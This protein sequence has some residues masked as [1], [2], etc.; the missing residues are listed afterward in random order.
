MAMIFDFFKAVMMEVTD[1][2]FDLLKLNNVQTVLTEAHLYALRN[3][4]TSLKQLEKKIHKEIP[5][6]KLLQDFRQLLFYLK[7][8]KSRTTYQTPLKARQAFNK[9]QSSATNKSKSLGSHN[10][11]NV[12]S[13]LSLQHNT[14]NDDKQTKRLNSSNRN[15]KI[16]T[17]QG[18]TKGVSHSAPKLQ[19]NVQE[20]LP[21]SSNNQN[22]QFWH[23]INPKQRGAKI[24]ENKDLKVNNSRQAVSLSIDSKHR[25]TKT[26]R[27]EQSTLS[28]NKV[29]T[30]NQSMDML[31][32]HI[33]DN[34]HTTTI[35]LPS[36]ADNSRTPTQQQDDTAQFSFAQEQQHTQ[37][38]LKAQVRQG[39]PT[40]QFST[41]K[42]HRKDMNKCYS[43]MNLQ[44]R[45]NIDHHH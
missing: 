39:E 33:S 14:N 1:S 20:Y 26:Q 23:L 31:K 15:S 4:I 5:S 44:P 28:F 9:R 10:L 37:D 22:T 25:T 8:L 36:L 34:Y 13:R 11:S 42:S 29:G 17:R 32:Q 40:L 35:N 16:S 21:L 18:L 27:Q 41:L 38:R 7:K 19:E 3:Q 24:G 6:L 2:G 45:T 12:I 43:Q 30:P